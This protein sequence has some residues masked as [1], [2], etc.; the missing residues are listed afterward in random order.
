MSDEYL[1]IL[2]KIY[3]RVIII[4]K[5]IRIPSLM[6]ENIILGGSLIW[7]SYIYER[8]R[9]IWCRNKS[10]KLQPKP[11]NPVL[12]TQQINND[13]K[14]PTNLKEWIT[15]ENKLIWFNPTD[16]TTKLRLKLINKL[17][18]P[19]HDI[20]VEI[21]E[22]NQINSKTIP[23][24]FEGNIPF[25]IKNISSIN[26]KQEP[27]VDIVLFLKG[28]DWQTI[29]IGNKETGRQMIL[30]EPNVLKVDITCKQLSGVLSAKIK[31][32]HNQYQTPTAEILESSSS[33]RN[34]MCYVFWC[35]LWAIL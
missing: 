34:I 32:G 9:F 11:E 33:Y 17:S 4:A 10:K 18:I 2:E 25:L 14:K 20:K 27:L 29:R 16:E 19:A 1:E 6:I 13:Q 8:P 3:D 21:V 22:L 35:I 12:D 26:S 30:Y 24:E 15:L 31:I 5:E 7:L 23:K 28:N